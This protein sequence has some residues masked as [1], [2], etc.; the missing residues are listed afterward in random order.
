MQL[1]IFLGFLLI[2]ITVVL[3]CLIK[4]LK[5]QKEINSSFKYAS[6]FECKEPHMSLLLPIFY[7]FV[8][9]FVA[10]I[11]VYMS[12]GGKNFHFTIESKVVAIVLG[13]IGLCILVKQIFIII[14]HFYVMISVDGDKIR[15]NNRFN[16]V[17]NLTKDDIIDLKVGSR[18]FPS[19]CFV[20][21]E[22]TSHGKVKKLS[23]YTHWEES[24][25]LKEWGRI[26]NK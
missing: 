20:R 25:L 12:E 1:L 6:R 13:L 15:L 17:F 16:E 11:L 2:V 22:F 14:S 18:R 24:L 21:I 10:F 4:N 23:M 5:H 8:I 19:D 26:Y 9:F 3:A 7:I